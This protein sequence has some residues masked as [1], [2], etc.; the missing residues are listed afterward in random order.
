MQLYRK[1]SFGRLAEFLV[2]DTRQYRT[3]QPNG[4]ECSRHQRRGHVARRLRCSA[5]GNAAGCRTSLTESPATWNVLAQQVMMGMVD[6]K[7][8]RAPRVLDGPLA[9]LRARAHA[10]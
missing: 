10:A 9:R 1:M 3:D 6:L 5:T 2:L 7:A 8:R 4:D